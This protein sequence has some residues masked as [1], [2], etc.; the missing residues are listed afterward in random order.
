VLLLADKTYVTPVYS[1]G[2]IEIAGIDSE[3]LIKSAG[4]GEL[5]SDIDD[6][7]SKI[8]YKLNGDDILIF[9]GA[10]SIT[11]WASCACEAFAKQI[12]QST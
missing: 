1:A 5:V 2:E 12:R 6:L 7:A 3:N 11:R 10:G 9:L 8:A 4:A